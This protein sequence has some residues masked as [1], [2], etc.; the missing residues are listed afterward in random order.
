MTIRPIPQNNAPRLLEDG[1]PESNDQFDTQPPNSLLKGIPLELIQHA[2]TFLN[3]RDLTIFGVTHRNI[4]TLSQEPAAFNHPQTIFAHRLMRGEAWPVREE[5]RLHPFYVS[6]KIPLISIQ[7]EGIRNANEIVAALDKET[8]RDLRLR[9]IPLHQATLRQIIGKVGDYYLVVLPHPREGVRAEDNGL[10]APAN[11][12]QLINLQTKEVR[13]FTLNKVIESCHSVAQPEP[14]LITIDHRGK[15]EKIRLT[16]LLE[17][18]DTIDFTKAEMMAPAYLELNEPEF[19]W[20]NGEGEFSLVAIQGNLLFIAYKEDIKLFDLS[21]QNGNR[22]LP[23]A[24]A[25]YMAFYGERLLCLSRTLCEVFIKGQNGNWVRDSDI[26]ISIDPEVNSFK[27]AALS[28]S[29]IAI[30]FN[31]V[32]PAWNGNTLVG[33]VYD[34]KTK[35][36]RDLLSHS[37]HTENDSLNHLVQCGEH[38]LGVNHQFSLWDWRQGKIGLPSFPGAI[39]TLEQS[40]IHTL[41]PMGEYFL[42]ANREHSYLFSPFNIKGAKMVMHKLFDTSFYYDGRNMIVSMEPTEE[43]LTVVTCHFPTDYREESTEIS[44]QIS[45]FNLLQ[46]STEA[47]AAPFSIEPFESKE[48]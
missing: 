16:Q 41:S 11:V 23:F 18:D 43:L 29:E 24:N 26:S 35:T 3:H 9:N 48:D 27:I 38:F 39:G 2:M 4:R 42:L 21:N 28:A 36:E 10:E 46:A 6:P 37:H 5:D 33:R 25:R 17:F 13:P 47:A 14:A 20:P 34:I 8:C 32:K 22:T 12:L 15:V 19:R 30:A 44:Q 7:C 45:V 31:Q 1:G 40:P